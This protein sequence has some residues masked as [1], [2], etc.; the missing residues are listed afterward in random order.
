MAYKELVKKFNIIR[1]YISDFYIYGYKNRY[2]YTIKSSRSYDNEKRRIESY[3]KD[4]MG[5][6]YTPLG[7]N[8]FISIDSRILYTNPFY[9]TLKTKSFTQKDIVFHF[10]IVDI[11]YD[12]NI[13]LTLKDIIN[14]IDNNYNID[15]VLDESLLRKKLKEYEEIG[16]IIKEKKDKNVYYKRSNYIDLKKWHNAIKFF[17]EIGLCGVIGSFIEDNINI[18]NNTFI[19]KHNYMAKALES[20]MLYNIFDVISEKRECFIEIYSRNKFREVNIVPLK[21]FVSSQTGR[22]YVMAYN[23]NMK[24]IKSYRLDYITDVK[25]GKIC[26]DFDILRDKLNNIQK[27]MWGVFLPYK[28]NINTVK[29]VLHINDNEEYIYKRLLREKRCGNVIRQD[30]NTVMFYCA[31]VDVDEMLPWIRSFIGRIKYFE[32]S[33]KNAEKRLYNDINE[34]YSM[35]GLGENL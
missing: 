25:K 5:F 28:Y 10:I 9:K 26:C 18:K 19:F 8:V 3:M 16:I 33:D 31:V 30:K 23:I 34:M 20:E 22:R 1:S 27:Y 12:D 32:F 15:F 29:F 24:K 6:R 4:Y 7:K 21:I 14:E 17:S 2:E 11:L 13:S 35:Y